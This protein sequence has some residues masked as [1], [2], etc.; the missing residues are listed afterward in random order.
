MAN[1]HSQRRGVIAKGGLGFGARVSTTIGRIPARAAC[2]SVW[3]EASWLEEASDRRL[4]LCLID[5]GVRSIGNI[6]GR[7]LP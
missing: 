3:S 4:G 1:G 2:L 6:R 7:F 5:S